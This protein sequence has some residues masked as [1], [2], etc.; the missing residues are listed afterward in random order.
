MGSNDFLWYLAVLSCRSLALACVAWLAL[1]VFR[2]KSASVKHAAWT[3]VAAVMLVQVVASP[4]LPPV[5][6]KVSAP[7]PDEGQP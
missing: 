5:P 7:V 6:L 2:V 4:A 3:V 1:R